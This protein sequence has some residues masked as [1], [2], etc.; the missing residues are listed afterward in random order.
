MI[1]LEN[2]D[3]FEK[4]GLDTDDIW[5]KISGKTYPKLMYMKFKIYFEILEKKTCSMVPL[6][7][8]A[9]FLVIFVNQKRQY[10]AENLRKS[11]HVWSFFSSPKSIVN[12]I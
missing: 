9:I 4:L 10:L 12:E 3:H 2:Q 11:C 6:E 1:S 8:T 7:N 5:R